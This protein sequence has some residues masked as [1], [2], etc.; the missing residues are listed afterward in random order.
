MP[1][2]APLQIITASS[3][4]EAML[5]SDGE[6]TTA[7]N[8]IETLKSA[9]HG[10]KENGSSSHPNGSGV[11]DHVPPEKRDHQ[12]WVFNKQLKIVVVKHVKRP[13]R[14]ILFCVTLYPLTMNTS[15]KA[16]L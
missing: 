3:D 11:D 16:V 9:N 10:A 15:K 13:G 8:H 6:E 2:E 7:S 1:D 5:G 12:N 4:E 14:G